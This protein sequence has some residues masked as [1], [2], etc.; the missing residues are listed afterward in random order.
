MIGCAGVRDGKLTGRHF[1]T[2]A[3]GD[4]YEIVRLCWLKRE[5]RWESEINMRRG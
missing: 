3:M 2:A 1:Y 4:S 5:K